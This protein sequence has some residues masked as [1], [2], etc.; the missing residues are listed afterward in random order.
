M[1]SEFILMKF[2]GH[3]LMCCH[4]LKRTIYGDTIYRND[5]CKECSQRSKTFEYTTENNKSF[6]LIESSYI[7]KNLLYV[8]PEM[9]INGEKNILTGD[10][11]GFYHYW[12]CQKCDNVH[13]YTDK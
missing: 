6:I 9:I 4:D 12:H 5:K 13:K 8:D 11:G 2:L 10:D 3:D 7:D 1:N